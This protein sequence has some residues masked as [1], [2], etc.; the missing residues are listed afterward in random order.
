MVKNRDAMSFF[1]KRCFVPR[2]GD[3]IKNRGAMLEEHLS[4]A[5]A[6]PIGGASF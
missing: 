3:E 1:N 4:G 5:D 2:L 6:P